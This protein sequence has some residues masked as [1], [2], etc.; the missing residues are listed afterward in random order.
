MDHCSAHCCTLQ[1]V[2]DEESVLGLNPVSSSRANDKKYVMSAHSGI[3]TVKTMNAVKVIAGE[4]L[5]IEIIILQQ[6]YPVPEKHLLILS[7]YVDPW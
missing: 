2:P 5:E 7:H 1:P 4:C 3:V 6:M